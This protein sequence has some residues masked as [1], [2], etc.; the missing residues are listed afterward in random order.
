MRNKKKS[1]DIFSFVMLPV[2]PL[3]RKKDAWMMAWLHASF[4][5]NDRIQVAFEKTGLFISLCIFGFCASL[6]GGI[7]IIII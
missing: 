3:A 2:L 4:C 1:K 7:L 6:F 5:S